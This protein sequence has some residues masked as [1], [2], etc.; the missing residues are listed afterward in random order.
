MSN[1]TTTEDFL[2]GRM[3]AF[4]RINEELTKKVKE[5]QSI[6]DKQSECKTL[7][8]DYNVLMGKYGDL[9]RKHKDLSKKY[10]VDETEIKRG[11]G[12][13]KKEQSNEQ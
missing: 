11:R 6:V 7:Q 2:L 3:L 1:Q 9:W 10:D 4:A 8:E 5:L 13:P 12:R